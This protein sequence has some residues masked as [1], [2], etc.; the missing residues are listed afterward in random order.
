MFNSG[1]QRADRHSRTA[2]TPYSTL[3][4]LIFVIGLS[5]S[6]QAQ[7]P[8][9]WLDGTE[10]TII[11]GKVAADAAD[12]QALRTECDAIAGVGSIPYAVEYP[13]A[14]NGGSS[15]TRGYTLNPAKSAGLVNAGYEG[16][17]WDDTIEQLG[18]CYQAIRT[19]DPARAAAYLL[20][21]HYILEAM[22]Q[23]LLK[24]VRQS[25]GQVRYA[26]SVDAQGSDLLAGAQAQVY[27]PY[28]SAKPGDIWTITGAQGCTSL[29][30]TFLVQ[31]VSANTILLEN[32]NGT[33]SVLNANCTLFSVSPTAGAAFSARF[34]MAAI[35]KAYDWFY[36]DGV[37]GGLSQMY[38]DDIA[39]AVRCMTAWVV[40][41]QYVTYGAHPETNYA[42]GYI[43]GAA[44]AYVAFNSDQPAAIGGPRQPSPDPALQRAE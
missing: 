44:A 38:P 16:G 11:R 10:L 23:P 40:E 2:I 13:H 6:A 22:A 19:T 29:N 35:A 27:Q 37:Y 12:W 41:S 32:T 33:A 25:D 24:M 4:V 21:A 42:A 20:E 1:L 5:I 17:L 26:T 36:G 15:P 14:S 43:W 7:H 18:E 31:A 34:Y 3:A 9:L 8:Y 39:N 28:S 30:G